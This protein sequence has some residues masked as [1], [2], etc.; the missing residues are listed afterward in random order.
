MADLST[1]ITAGLASGAATAA[2]VR[3]G[4]DRTGKV[5][6]VAAGTLAASLSDLNDFGLDPELIAR[7]ISAAASH[8]AAAVELLARLPGELALDGTAATDAFLSSQIY[9]SFSTSDPARASWEHGTANV[10]GGVTDMSWLERIRSAADHHLDGLIAA[11]QTPEFWQRTLGNALEAGV[12]S[13]AITAVDQLL[14]HRDELIN[15]TAGARRERL[16]QILQTS[17]LMAAGAMPVSVFLS[18]ALM[19]V[20]GL[21]GVTVPLG[22][23]GTAGLGLRLITSAVRNP[24]RQ[25]RQAVRQLQG[26]LQEMLYALQR[27]SDGS[28]TIT[29]PAQ[30]AN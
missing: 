28:L 20:P 7:T 29:V 30:P 26:L 13:A 4:L 27:D 1:F 3:H 10:A 21:A 23:I 9:G 16:V 14:V 17:G 11:A 19:L 6:A 22:V 2:K 8:G 25:E 5:L 18:V 15:G 12:Y 24:S